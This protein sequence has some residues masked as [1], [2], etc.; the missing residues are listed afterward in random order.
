MSTKI[1]SRQAMIVAMEGRQKFFAE[2]NAEFAKSKKKSLSDDEKTLQITKMQEQI[3]ALEE[4]WR[5]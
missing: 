1:S 4:N 5:L 3:K 2:M